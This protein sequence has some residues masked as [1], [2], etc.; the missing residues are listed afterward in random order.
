MS[1]HDDLFEGSTMSFGEHLEELRGA[2]I[3]AIYCLVGGFVIGLF[4][5]ETVVD[6]IKAPV[7]EALQR[8]Y[9]D[10]AERDIKQKLQLPNDFVS[11]MVNTYKLYPQQIQ[12]DPYALSDA[13]LQ[14]NAAESNG[15]ELPPAQL[16]RKKD[17]TSLRSFAQQLQ[18]AS[19]LEEDPEQPN[20][21]K[22]LWERIDPEI[23]ELIN[24]A[25]EGK[26]L[27]QYEEKKLFAA[28]NRTLRSEPFDPQADMPEDAL[29]SH[30]AIFNGGRLS[31]ALPAF[32]FHPE[33]SF[34][35]VT[36]WQT[37]QN[38]IGTK[39]RSL[40]AQEM[41]LIFL[42]AAF[43]FGFVVAS[44]GVFYFLWQFVAEGLYPH[45]KKYVH[46]FLPISVFLFLAGSAVA[47][48]FVFQF[49]LDFL[50]GFNQMLG[51]DPDIRFSE[52]LGFAL[53]LPVGFGI[54]FQL[55]LVMFFLERVGIFQVDDFIKN[56]R[57][58]IMV[59][60][61]L[62]AVLTPGDPYSMI[63]M[64]I[65]LSGLYFL[66]IWMCKVWPQTRNPYQVPAD[67]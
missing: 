39:I 45:E 1:Q 33:E 25:A 63:L 13:L 34:L 42:K 43:V 9:L 10:Q 53:F 15:L 5:A 44:P 32:E 24:K 14:Q 37:I 27:Q 66:G 30:V 51:V 52:W 58:A 48:F 61:V 46:I 67:I 7:E 20:A 40:S 59:I 8:Y 31:Q 29:P 55:P 26:E 19:E 18:K 62:S 56:W 65:P 41:F 57:P 60:C 50:L 16:I 11:E 12:I 22:A 54:S 47:Y 3:K 6:W 4:F 49:V 2:L 38:H 23:R 35:N 21:G 17:L 64:G 28:L 36:M